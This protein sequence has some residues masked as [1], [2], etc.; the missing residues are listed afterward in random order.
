MGKCLS[1]VFLSF[2]LLLLSMQVH[3]D[4]HT[5]TNN[6]GRLRAGPGRHG[7]DVRRPMTSNHR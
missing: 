3:S 5:K 7:N 6:L 2:R 4:T 1:L